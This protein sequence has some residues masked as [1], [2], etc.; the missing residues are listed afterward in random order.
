M[1]NLSNWLKSLDGQSRREFKSQFQLS[2]LLDYSQVRVNQDFLK[3]ATEFW[4]PSRHVFRFNNT[5][6]CPTMEEFGAIL[7]RPDFD[8]ILLPSV[9]PLKVEGLISSLFGIPTRVA[10]GWFSNSRIDFQLVVSHFSQLPPIVTGNQ[11]QHRLNALC[12]CI[13]ACYLF[14][15]APDSA[16][17]ALLQILPLLRESNPS[18]MVLAGTL[19]ALDRFVRGEVPFVGG[20]PLL[21]QV[22]S[23]S[24]PSILSFSFCI[25]LLFPSSVRTHVDGMRT[26]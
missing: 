26:H 9:V 5:E 13:L 22:N 10:R 16:D 11:L 18:M 20:S 12:F 6:V 4:D 21:L 8:H 15:D 17:V 25:W 14:V 7:G 2:S 19:N 3:L 23:P 24:F 1:A